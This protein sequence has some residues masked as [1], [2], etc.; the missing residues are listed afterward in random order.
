[1]VYYDVIQDKA[2][3][4]IDFKSQNLQIFDFALDKEYEI[5]YYLSSDSFIYFF[6]VVDTIRNNKYS[7]TDNKYWFGSDVSSI[8]IIEYPFNK[9]FYDS[10]NK[11][12]TQIGCQ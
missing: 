7:R 5:I 4:S 11:I 2:V 10:S 6:S 8:R 12:L 9:L 3:I 1:M